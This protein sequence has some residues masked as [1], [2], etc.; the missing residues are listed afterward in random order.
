MT[1]DKVVTNIA[2]NL[3]NDKWCDDRFK[4]IFIYLYV[5]NNKYTYKN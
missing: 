2:I 5:Y 3:L 1:N 4:Y